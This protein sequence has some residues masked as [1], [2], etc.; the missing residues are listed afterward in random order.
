[1]NKS[2]Y[3]LKQALRKWNEKL[4]S[5]LKENGFRQSKSDYS[6]FVKSKGD[7]FIALLVYVDDIVLIGNNLEETNRYKTF[8]KSKFLIK[9]LGKLKYFLGIEVVDID[10]GLYLK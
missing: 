7:L 1:M 5:A 3:G 6:L 9:D 10:S 8:M 4:T 2:L